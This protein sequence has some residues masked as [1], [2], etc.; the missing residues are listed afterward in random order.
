MNGLQSFL[1]VPENR[2]RL[3]GLRTIS[4][5][6][7]RIPLEEAKIGLT[8]HRMA[9]VLAR[10]GKYSDAEMMAKEALQH[11]ER[12]WS[13]GQ[14]SLLQINEFCSARLA[15]EYKQVATSFM[16]AWDD[17]TVLKSV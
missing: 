10:E 9:T 2:P 3:P 8:K 1:H 12:G 16:D 13:R 6:Q 17:G 15:P 4:T 7:W 11:N 5:P 14:C